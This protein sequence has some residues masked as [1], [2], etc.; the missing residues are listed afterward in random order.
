MKKNLLFTLSMLIKVF[1]LTF[2]FS[3]AK[4]KEF[5]FDRVNELESFLTEEVKL[6]LPEKCLVIIVTGSCNPCETE[7]L[8]LIHDID[9]NIKIVDAQNIILIPYY[10]KDLY[11]SLKLKNS[12]VFYDKYLKLQ[13]YGLYF[14]DNILV[15]FSKKSGVIYYNKIKSDNIYIIRKAIL[16]R[17]S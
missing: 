10:R 16:V 11:D 4:E 12:V 17:K 2:C 14:N 6:P 3:C 8:A 7:T 15:E 13:N 1:V 9:S 5:D